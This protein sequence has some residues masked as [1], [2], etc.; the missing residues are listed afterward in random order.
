MRQRNLVFDV[1]SFWFFEVSHFET[2]VFVSKKFS[3]FH[4]LTLFSPLLIK[5][6][7]FRYFTQPGSVRLLSFLT[8][9][10]TDKFFESSQTLFRNSHYCPA[11]NL[12]AN[13]KLD[14]K[15]VFLVSKL[16]NL[17]AKFW[18]GNSRQ[19]YDYLLRKNSINNWIYMK[20]TKKTWK[21]ATLAPFFYQNNA[22]FQGRKSTKERQVEVSSE[23]RLGKVN[24]HKNKI[25]T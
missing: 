24:T 14:Y 5:I 1:R 19:L 2:T 8:I 20:I 15:L 10:G 23:Q 13:Q 6:A 25:S 7:I 12:I 4:S 18:F 3:K 11:L 16:L 9:N 21:V 22:E 17:G